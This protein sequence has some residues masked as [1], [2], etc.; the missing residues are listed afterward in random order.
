MGKNNDLTDE[1]EKTYEKKKS[2]KVPIILALVAIIIILAFALRYSIMNLFMNP[3]QRMAFAFIN[4]AKV[5]ID[6]YDDL[7]EGYISALKNA[8]DINANIKA[9]L[10][11]GQDASQLLREAGVDASKYSWITKASYQGTYVSNES[12]QKTTGDLSINDEDIASLTAIVD[13]TDS[14]FYFQLP[15]ISEKYLGYDLASVDYV[16]IYE[17]YLAYAASA[18]ENA[19]GSDEI[20]E[21][22]DKYLDLYLVGWSSVEEKKDDLTAAGL[23]GR[24]TRIDATITDAEL[25]KGKVAVLTEALQDEKL[26]KFIESMMA[27]SYSLGG[28]TIDDLAY[29][30]TTYDGILQKWQEEL[31]LASKELAG[32]NENPDSAQTAYNV[33]IY[34]TNSNIIKGFCLENL[35]DEKSIY[36]YAPESGK[37]IGLAA[38]S[39]EDAITTELTGQGTY[40]GAKLSGSFT[41]SEGDSLLADFILTDF[42]EKALKDGR[43]VGRVT[44]TPHNSAEDN[45]LADT[46]Y[47]LS[48]NLSKDE[49]DFDLSLSQSNQKLCQIDFK[50]IRNQDNALTWPQEDDVILITSDDSKAFVKYC[51]TTDFTDFVDGLKAAGMSNELVSA[52]DTVTDYIEEGD[53]K[54][55]LLGLFLMQAQ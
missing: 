34:V 9:D 5:Q 46:T 25:L 35:K 39:T 1:V 51:K 33:T 19:L 8:D 52:I 44:F 41:L 6:K 22:A 43:L 14:K 17:K 50:A 37:N 55:L 45:I 38:G 42:D 29:F 32:Y 11:M 13:R 53:L 30:D 47:D 23:T 10:T 54:S 31:E 4:T 40:S 48:F 3:E 16:S 12:G 24:Y 18:G 36:L 7:Y 20:K 49:S 2:K 28:Y 21:L 15:T 27:F 26:K